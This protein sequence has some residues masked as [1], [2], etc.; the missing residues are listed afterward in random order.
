MIKLFLNQTLLVQIFNQIYVL[1]LE[2]FKNL[3]LNKSLKSDI[4]IKIIQVYILDLMIYK[5]IIMFIV[6]YSI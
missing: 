2:I 5:V 3:I 1:L 4:G 6:M